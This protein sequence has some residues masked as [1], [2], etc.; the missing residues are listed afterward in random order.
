MSEVSVI[1]VAAGEGRRFG[2]SKQFALLK[3]KSV[4]DWCLEKF[5]S[6]KIVSNIILVLPDDTQQAKYID[7]YKK[8]SAVTR[9]GKMRQDSVLSGF[10]HVNP[11][12][13]DIVLIHDGVR[14]LIN[15]SLIDRVIKAVQKRGAAIPV[16][17]VEDTVKLIEAKRVLRTVDREKLYRVQTPQ[18]F[19][20]SVL[21]A[22]FNKAKEEDYCVSDEA[23]LVE[24]MG[25]EVMAV[26][27]DRLNIKITTPEDLRIAEAIIED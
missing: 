19:S 4:L 16:I 15:K 11:K 2:S 1:I 10:H 21:E 7:C 14:P 8:V 3:G 12:K 13:A 20:Y 25:G 27:G 6:H 18:G 23:A 5:E 9:G 24:R 22:A 26:P 17:P